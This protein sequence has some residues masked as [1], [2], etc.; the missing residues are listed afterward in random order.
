MECSNEARMKLSYTNYP[1]LDYRSIQ[2]S[3]AYADWLQLFKISGSDL[4]HHLLPENLLL[5]VPGTEI[6]TISSNELWHSSDSAHWPG[7]PTTSVLGEP[8]KWR[9]IG[10]PGGGREGWDENLVSH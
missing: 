10:L 6:V 7:L 5:E 8:Y 3:I 1:A 2:V 4:A 9:P